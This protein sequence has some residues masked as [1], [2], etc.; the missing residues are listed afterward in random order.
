MRLL[1]C[2]LT[3]SQNAPDIIILDE[4]TNNLD[5]QNIGILTAAIRDYTGTLIVISHDTHFLEQIGVSREIMLE[6]SA[7][8]PSLFSCN[9]NR[10]GKKGG[11]VALENNLYLVGVFTGLRQIVSERVN[12]VLLLPKHKRFVVNGSVDP[13]IFYIGAIIPRD[14]HLAGNRIKD[15]FQT[16]ELLSLARYFNR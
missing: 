10:T 8:S 9:H 4:P 15:R 12:S 2:C 11:L 16:G 1:L 5:L 7:S 13:I 6:R 3:I 14:H